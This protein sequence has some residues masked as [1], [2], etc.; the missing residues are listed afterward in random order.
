MRYLLSFVFVLALTFPARAAIHTETIEYK[1]NDAVL[2]GYLAYDDSTQSKRPGI[3]VVHEWKG[4]GSYA[5]KRTEQLAALGYVAFAVDMYGKGIRPTTNEEA[6]KQAGIYKSDRPLMRARVLAGLDVLKKQSLVDSSNLAAIGYCFGGTT[7]LELARSGADVKGVVSFH[8]GLSTPTP[9]D[10]K[11]IKARV[12]ALHGADD[13]FVP[14]PEVQAF[15]DEMTKGKVQWKLIPYPGA[16]HSFTNPD[17]GNDPSKG[18]AYNANAD[19]K[20]WAEMKAFLSELF[21]KK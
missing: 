1:H 12:L 21:F 13:P 10:A 4:L 16:V 6:A 3:L 9:D 19:Q 18:M 20:S 17:S 7:V 5:K 2:E 11:N 14:P 8:G 15:K